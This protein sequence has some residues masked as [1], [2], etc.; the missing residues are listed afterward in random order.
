[1]QRKRTGA[2]ALCVGTAVALAIAPV[3]AQAAFGS[4]FAADDPQTVE[5]SQTYM[6]SAGAKS[7]EWPE[8]T[9]DATGRWRLLEVRDPVEDP[10]WQRPSTVKTET[11]SVAVASS[12]VQETADSFEKTI[13]YRKDG[14]AGV[15]ERCEVTKTPRYE[16]LTRQVDR[17]VTLSGYPD[18]DVSQLPQ[19]MDFEV[20]T[21]DALSSTAMRPLALSDVTW[22]ISETDELGM[23]TGY[24]ALCNYRGTEDYLTIPSYEVACTWSGE[25]FQEDTRMISSAVY[26]LEEPFPWWIVGAGIALFGAGASAVA[27]TL[28]VRKRR[29]G[30]LWPG[31]NTIRKG[32]AS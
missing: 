22:S 5:R 9:Q 18:N 17:L 24:T 11:E 4:A 10:S 14:F 8:E 6:E 29:F 12:E 20:T 26:V 27:A 21:A 3:G 28:H 1:M 19:T 16:V 25:V 30:L 2:G 15:L 23:P 7:I 31:A 13:E 32:G